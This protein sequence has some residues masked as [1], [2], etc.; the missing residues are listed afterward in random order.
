MRCACASISSGFSGR[1][2][3]DTTTQS[4]PNTLAA[5]WPRLTSMPSEA[6]RRVTA[7]SALSE[8]DT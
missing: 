5:A 4:A 2:A 3:L 6:N 7:L 1:I 8:P